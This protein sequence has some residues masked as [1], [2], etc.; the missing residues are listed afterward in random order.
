MPQLDIC[1]SMLWKPII[2]VD[3]ALIESYSLLAHSRFINTRPLSMEL[4]KL[5]FALWSVDGHEPRAIHIHTTIN[6]LSNWYRV[7]DSC[8]IV[9]LKLCDCHLLTRSDDSNY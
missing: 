8:G 1:S 9:F 3:V 6:E 5:M 4:T 2:V 7:I